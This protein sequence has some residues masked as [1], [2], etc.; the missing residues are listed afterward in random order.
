MQS[1]FSK[2]T[3][4][5]ENK[6]IMSRK[7]SSNVAKGILKDAGKSSISPRSPGNGS[8]N[9]ASGEQDLRMQLDENRSQAYK[10][11][12]R[13]QDGHLLIG[14]QGSEDHIPKTEAGRERDHSAE[15]RAAVDR[16]D[17]SRN[18]DYVESR[19]KVKQS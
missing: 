7:A 1:P 16:Y 18:E 9:G 13:V 8:N 17:H 10:S 14:S 12:D 2:K 19:S 5:N 6:D 4:S 3:G 11:E 15:I